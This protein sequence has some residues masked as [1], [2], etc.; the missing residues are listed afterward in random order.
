[1]AFR[2]HFVSHKAMHALEKKLWV[3]YASGE[4]V[5][6]LTLGNKFPESE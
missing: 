2:R 1:M 5:S 4:E 3:C 6:W